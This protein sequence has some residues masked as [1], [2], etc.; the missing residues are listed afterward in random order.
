MAA[1]YILYAAIIDGGLF[2][3]AAADVLYAA[4]RYCDKVC[5]AV[6]YILRVAVI[7][8]NVAGIL[9]GVYV[10][11]CPGPGRR[12]EQGVQDLAAALIAKGQKVCDAFFRQAVAVCF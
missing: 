11:S 1:L 8:G 3:I 12:K 7:K 2:S 4:A 5:L 10:G 6:L 9:A